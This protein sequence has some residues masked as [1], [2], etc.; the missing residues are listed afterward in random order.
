MHQTKIGFNLLFKGICLLSF[1]ALVESFTVDIFS[2]RSRKTRSP[3]LSN[4]QLSHAAFERKVSCCFH[5]NAVLFVHSSEGAEKILQ[6]PEDEIIFR[7]LLSLRTDDSKHS[8]LETVQIVQSFIESF[9]FP[10]VLPVQ[11]MTYIPNA[12]GYG[13][14]VKFLRK[15]TGEKGSVDGGIDFSVCAKGLEDGTSGPSKSKPEMVE[16]VAK[17]NSN[18][19]TFPKTFSEM[20]ITKAFVSSI[21]DVDDKRGNMTLNEMIIVEEVETKWI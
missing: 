7:I 16:I 3:L 17:R 12:E 15:K 14:R 5:R 11:P 6:E 9:P 2:L 20:Q 18:G 13:V 10:S 4:F 1:I 8:T 19:Q 21:T